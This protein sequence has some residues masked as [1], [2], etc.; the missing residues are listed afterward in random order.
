[1]RT[2][3]DLPSNSIDQ[4]YYEA[5]VRKFVLERMD[6][7]Q[8]SFIQP[9]ERYKIIAPTWNDTDYRHVVMQGTVSDGNAYAMGGIAGH[10]GL[11]STID[12][13]AKLCRK[14]LW[15]SSDDDAINSTTVSTFTKCVAS[16][17]GL[18][19]CIFTDHPRH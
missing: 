14:L 13:T 11:F 6:M 1:L 9:T 8:S 5:F 4:C 7:T 19:S 16:I 10:A 18:V 15:A 3:D 12:D 17:V 2:T